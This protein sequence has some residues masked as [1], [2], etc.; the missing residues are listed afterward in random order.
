M[1]EGKKT[2]VR[3]T[4]AVIG[5]IIGAGLFALPAMFA[6]TGVLVGSIVYWVAAAVVLSTHLL[7]LELIRRD[8]ERRRFP[9]YIGNIL[10][11]WAKRLG[12][13]TQGCQLAGVNL[14]YI[15]L[16]GEFLG[17]IAIHL[18]LA[19]HP[20]VWQLL[21][22]AGG[23]L[24]VFFVLRVMAKIEA[25]LT[26]MLIVVLVTIIVFAGFGADPSRFVGQNWTEA[27]A[28][29]GVFIFAMFGLTVLPEVHEIVA[30]DYKRT[31][32]A[33]V[34]GTLISALLGWLF[35]VFVFA[36]LLAG[37]SSDASAIAT[38]LP[39]GLW[40]L[41]PLVGFLAV[42]TSYI[43]ATFDMHAILRVDFGRSATMAR[44]VALGLPLFLLVVS[45][46][47]FL[48]VIGFVGGLFTATNGLLVTVAARRML[49]AERRA[50][51]WWRGVVPIGCA[52]FYAI[53]I[54]QRLVVTS[55]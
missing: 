11:P 1:F 48:S 10:G 43:T 5:T 41:V 21:F 47:S 7:F 29:L 55:S 6:R 15:L 36:A 30:R 13:M 22:W 42:I 26:W 32:I 28:P 3:A 20:V 50:P 19:A 9:G 8:S 25:V 4:L 12:V 49:L 44:V 23:A 37:A 16:G 45:Q 40:V 27:A 39:N 46:Q 52:V 35:G 38:I 31:R 24:T 33:V 51:W 54:F 17:V 53:T 2:L 34:I 14:A 18:G